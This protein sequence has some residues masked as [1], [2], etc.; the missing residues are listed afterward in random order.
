MGVRCQR[1]DPWSKQCVYH[2]L[3]F[4]SVV[5]IPGSAIIIGYRNDM[6]LQCHVAIYICLF[7]ASTRF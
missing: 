1:Y 2:F 3:N 6:E 7:G 4:E 5:H